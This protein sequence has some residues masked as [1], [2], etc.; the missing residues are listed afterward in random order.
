MTVF[1]IDVGVYNTHVEFIFASK[2]EHVMLA[3][4]IGVDFISRE[5]DRKK[6]SGYYSKAEI[7]NHGFLVGIVSD[8]LGNFNKED[9]A[10]RYAYNV[11]G[12]ILKSRGLRRDIKNISYLTEYIKSKIEFSELE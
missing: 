12:E 8:S 9:T 3:E 2:K 7:P 4:E 1:N 6:K 10:A 11:A 5:V